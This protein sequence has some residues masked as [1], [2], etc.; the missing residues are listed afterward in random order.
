MWSRLSCV[1]QHH[2]AR[3]IELRTNGQKYQYKRDEDDTRVSS[4]FMSS[5]VYVFELDHFESFNLSPFRAFNRLR[6]CS[7]KH[8]YN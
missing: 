6:L 8:I 3:E 2:I 5:D 4:L 1:L 7:I